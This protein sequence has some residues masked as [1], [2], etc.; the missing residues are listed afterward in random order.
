MSTFSKY[1]SALSFVG[2]IAVGAVLSLAVMRLSGL[3]LISQD[4]LDEQLR[5][6]ADLQKKQP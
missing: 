3:A 2:G 1:R 6:I 4:D 5:L